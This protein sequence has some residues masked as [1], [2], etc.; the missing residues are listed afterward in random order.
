MNH[1]ELLAPAGSFEALKAALQ[2]GADAVY[3]GGKDFS[4]RAYASNFDRETLREAVAYSH[5]RGMKVYVTVNT[6][7]K[8][9]E[10][11]ALME[12]IDF[13]Y[14]IDVDA[15][16]L[17]DIGA[18]QLIK[19]TYPDFELHCSTQMTLHNRQGVALLKEMGAGRAVLARELPIDE[20]RGIK[21]HTGIELEVFVHGALCV[22]Y[23]GQCLMSSFIGGRSGNRGKCAQP[24]RRAYQLVTNDKHNHGE[25]AL[26]QLSMRDLNTLEEIGALIEAG[27]TSFKIEGRMKKPQYVASIVAAYRRAIDYYLEKNKPLI[28]E[29]LQ[30]EMAQ[31]FN[32]RFTKGYL[33]N[34]PKKE[35]INIEKP[36][37]RGT[38]LGKVKQYNQQTKRL[39]L[40]LMGQVAL[41]DGI[42]VWQGTNSDLGGIITG[43]YV[44]KRPVTK[45]DKGQLVELEIKG[46]IHQGDM[47]YKTL[48]M[49][50]MERLEKTY[51]HHTENNKIT[52]EGEINIRFQTPLQLTLWDQEGNQVY[53]ES[54]ILPERAVKV[55]LEKTRVIE[56]IGKLGNTPY[57][58]K[59]LRVVLEEGLAVPIS[60]LN[61]LRRE[62]IEELSQIRRTRYPQRHPLNE[63]VLQELPFKTLSKGVPPKKPLLSVKVDSVKQLEAVLS[64]PVDRVYYGDINTFPRAI[65]YCIQHGVP[66]YLRTPGI[67]RE[68]DFAKIEPYLTKEKIPGVLIGD[69]GMIKLLKN[70]GEIPA[71]ADYHLNV[72]NSQSLSQFVD[73]GMKGVT[74]SP[75]LDFKAIRALKISSELEVEAVVYGRLPVMTMEYCPL[76]QLE[77]CNHQCHRCLKAPYQYHW[78]LKDQK[79]MTFPYGKDCWGRTIIL[80]SQVL[81]MID[82]LE[83]FTKMGIGI[84]RIEFTDEGPVEI[85]ETIKMYHN[86]VKSAYFNH[87]NDALEELK[88]LRQGYTRGHYYRGVE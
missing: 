29:A 35:V 13:L 10:L 9:K 60:A 30:Q 81:H 58:L 7:M 69:L 43:L 62:A 25:K 76:Q 14:G 71:V 17:Q 16:I 63:G 65:G 87:P 37:N 57:S 49:A 18:F 48:D 12:Y 85:A 42:E 19:K 34:S 15:L 59:D 80:N 32:R 28:D 52:I 56:N 8:D 66:I 75:E 83:E 6:L 36:N 67:L 46:K 64:Q 27:V 2:N 53:R 1:I 23:S 70:H 40:Q 68:S 45:A 4:A 5:I 79:Q 44:D 22:S 41:G 77:E 55:A 39:Q 21:A 74:L 33:F 86:Q 50:L 88:H 26:Y 11:P 38:Y 73:W 61:S 47:V 51:G 78:G 31:M 54:S 3:L 20:I 84:L 72:M 24:C 82:R